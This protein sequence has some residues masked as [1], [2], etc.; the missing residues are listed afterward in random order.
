MGVSEHMTI[1]HFRYLFH[2][3]V[4][5][6]ILKKNVWMFRKPIEIWNERTNESVKFKRLD[7]ALS[8]KLDGESVRDIVL[9]LDALIIPAISGGRGASGEQKEFSFGHAN[10]RGGGK[11]ASIPPAYANTKIKAKTL[12]GALAEFKR[13]HLLAD[14]E[15]AYE[16]DDQG[17]VHQYKK[18]GSSSVAI[19]SSRNARGSIIIHNHPSGGAF[20]DSDLISTASD[21][22]N[23][24]I[25][26]SG[27]DHDYKFEKGSHFKASQF[28]QA[29]KTAKMKGKDYDDA[30]DKWM[31][32]NQKKYG[33]K[34]SRTK[35]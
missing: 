9:R 32:N 31:K 26:A 34:Y 27:K 1:E 29:V 18:G 13:N 11:G 20:S 7:D 2:N 21:Q 35:N 33:Y 15:F 8:Y 19:S 12:D 30:V 5:G 23:K 24:G 16:V 3:E 14:R 6:F 28:I 10:D 22:R 25:I 4:D 17:F